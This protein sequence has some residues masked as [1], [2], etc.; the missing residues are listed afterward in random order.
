MPSS[1]FRVVGPSGPPRRKFPRPLATPRPPRRRRGRKSCRS[2]AGAGKQAMTS[3]S[4][5]ITLAVLVVSPSSVAAPAQSQSVETTDSPREFTNLNIETV[6]GLAPAANG[7]LYALNTHASQI[8]VHSDAD[9][10]PEQLWQTLLYPVSLAIWEDKL[11][12]VGGG[13]H[14]LA[15][16][17]A[18]NGD[19]LKVLQLPSEPADLVID[20]VDAQHARA[21]VACQGTNEVVKVDLNSFEIADRYPIP[22]ESPRMLHLEKNGAETKVYVA[23]FLSGNNSTVQNHPDGKRSTVL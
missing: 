19:I 2:C 13:T 1:M 17:D 8:V 18:A 5:W 22:A 11:V 9:P 20:V 15:L 23:P 12:V 16:H 6:R 3:S 21:F 4:S 7:T 14:A 10:E